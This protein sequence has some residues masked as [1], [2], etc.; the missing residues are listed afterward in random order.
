MNDNLV[1]LC[2]GFETVTSYGILKSVGWKNSEGQYHRDDDKPA[3]I[4]YHQNGEIK[5]EYYYKNGKAIV[6]RSYYRGGA[7]KSHCC[8]KDQTEETPART[9]YYSDGKVRSK[10]WFDKGEGLR[11][12]T[13]HVTGELRSYEFCD[14]KTIYYQS[15]DWRLNDINPKTF[16]DG[17][18]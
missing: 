13:Y 9:T 18:W 8:T 17:F 14:G 1:A 3:K 11:E 2:E 5:G 7:L 15:N 12:I 10:T 16:D 4:E 6:I